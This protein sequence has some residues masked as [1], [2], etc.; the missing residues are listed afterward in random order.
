M[1][2]TGFDA[3]IEQV[4][5][6]D[7]PLREHTLLQAIARVNRTAEGK[8]YGLIVDYW[9]VSEALTEALNIFTP[10]DVKGAMEPKVDELPRLQARHATVLRFFVGVKDKDDL[11]AC[12][13]ALEAEDVRS[14]FNDAFRKFSQ[15]LDM[16]LPDPIALPY[17][18]DAKWIGKIRQVAASRY[19]D[20]G[21][22]ISDCGAKVRKL[23]E[24]AI[25]ADGIQILVKQISLFAPDF[26]ERLKALKGDDARAS[27]MEHAIRNEIHV[28]YDENPA[29]Y[30][31]LRERLEK[32][33]EDRKAKRIDAAQQLSLMMPLKADVHGETNAA[34]K[35]GLSDTAFALYGLFLAPPTPGTIAERPG[36]GY[37][38]SV[39]VNVDEEKKAL[40]T[41]VEDLLAPSLAIVDWA[42]KEDV[43]REMRMYVRRALRV[44]KVPPEAL[45]AMID[46]VMDVMRRRARDAALSTDR[47]RDAALSTDRARDAALSTDR[48]R[49]K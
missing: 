33:I 16:L 44:A 40:A 31:S 28:R 34:R 19:R 3:P 2:L 15:S 36:P 35:L 32:L 23:I 27:E 38:P 39:N 29:F 25:A 41:L 10:G 18:R 48:A 1:L 42:K 14:Q 8:T 17:A 22:D 46:A 37:G 6:L 26:E 7:S 21:V 24:E 4:M 20:P 49:E 45:E 11:N 47:A 30:A 43:Q 9:G 13:A 12:V 5:Y